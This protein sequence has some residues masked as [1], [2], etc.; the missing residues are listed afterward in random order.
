MEDLPN[1]RW[2][3]TVAAAVLPEGHPKETSLYTSRYIGVQYI[4]GDNNGCT[5]TSWKAF[6][7]KSKDGTGRKQYIGTYRT[8]RDAALAHDCYAREIGCTTLNFKD[9]F[10]YEEE[11]KKL[12]M[13]SSSASS[14]SSSSVASLSSCDHDHDSITHQQNHD[15]PGGDSNGGGDN[16]NN[17]LLQNEQNCP[18][19]HQELSLTTNNEI[20][21]QINEPVKVTTRKQSSSPGS[22]TNQELIKS[23]SPRKS[24]YR[25]VVWNTGHKRNQ[26]KAQCAI[27]KVVQSLGMCNGKGRRITYNI[28]A[29]ENEIEAAVAYDEILRKHG[30][31]ENEKYL[32]FPEQKNIIN[33]QCAKYEKLSMPDTEQNGVA[34]SS[35]NHIVEK[36]E[37]KRKRQVDEHIVISEK[38][39]RNGSNG[40]PSAKNDDITNNNNNN[41]LCLSSLAVGDKIAFDFGSDIF[42]GNI[43][44][45][46]THNKV[47]S[48]W[49][50]NVIF[51]DGERYEFDYKEILSSVTLYEKLKKKEIKSPQSEENNI[52][53]INRKEV[54]LSGLAVG[55]RIA[56]YFGS[57]IYFGYVEECDTNNKVKTE[58]NF[59]VCFDDGE[60][61]IFDYEEMSSA[62]NL[63][64]EL[65]MKELNDPDREKK[66]KK[67]KDDFF[68]QKNYVLSTIPKKVKNQFLQV[69][70]ALWQKMY[71]PVLFLGPYD[72]S[73]GLVRDEWLA[74]FETVSYFV[75]ICCIYEY[76]EMFC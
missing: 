75:C 66:V 32:N 8:E 42:F 27:K 17:K 25:G 15:N 39:S 44:K 59:D 4:M 5:T 1:I 18:N 51:D 22:T 67:I 53:N 37:T 76:Y 71:L 68:I 40:K 13:S 29:F 54:C 48:Q 31:G 64:E 38:R 57:D 72:V 16:K 60:R 6:A 47:K 73:P 34:V 43:E 63:Y 46:N 74:A 30:G 69:G 45:C 20:P 21:T 10:I 49:N 24:A 50:W 70:F 11:D 65:K 33:V 9:E 58:W 55:E 35:N 56:F 26:W 7:P 28:G 36:Q 52:N 41:K 12:R 19:L 14:S 23:S 2:L 61:Y 3:D 62:V